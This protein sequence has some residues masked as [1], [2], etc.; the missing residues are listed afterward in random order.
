MRAA[1]SCLYPGG[2]TVRPLGDRM[3]HSTIRDYLRVA[4][5][6]STGA[7]DGDL[8]A[9]FAATRDE[10][11]FELLV[12]RH[13]GLVQRVCRAVLRDHHAAEDAAQAAFLVLARKAHTFAGRG[14]VV[15]WLYRV[16]RRVSVRLARRRARG[17]LPSAELD[18]VPA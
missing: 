13:A 11:A 15:G 6:N 18:R 8:L 9:R 7:S 3:A 4:A 2:T 5:G 10:S 14:S 12:W 1:G 16:A 17:P